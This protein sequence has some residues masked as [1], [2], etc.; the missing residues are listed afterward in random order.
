MREFYG[1]GTIVSSYYL[2]AICLQPHS[3]N[4]DYSRLIIGNQYLLCGVHGK[5]RPELVYGFRVSSVIEKTP[6]AGA[7]LGSLCR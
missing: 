6:G 7:F 2:I 1:P 3:E 5:F 4:H